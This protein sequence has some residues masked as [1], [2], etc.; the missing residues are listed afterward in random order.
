MHRYKMG[1]LI[2]YKWQ[3]M[4]KIDIIPFL[5]SQAAQ[6]AKR[7]TL[8]WSGCSRGLKTKAGLNIYIHPSGSV[9]D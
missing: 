9:W 6:G 4:Y 1:I 3:N 7:N 5:V 2:E 8:R